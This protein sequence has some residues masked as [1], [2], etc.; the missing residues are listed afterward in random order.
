MAIS[1]VLDESHKRAIKEAQRRLHDLVETL[2]AAEACGLQCQ[3]LRQIHADFL[4]KL[5]AI[6]QHFFPHQ[7][8]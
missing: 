6:E 7:P 8:S 2:A 5:Q 1:G 4:S 3:D